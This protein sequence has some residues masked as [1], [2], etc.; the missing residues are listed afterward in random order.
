[1]MLFLNFLRSEGR[2]R[3]IEYDRRKEVGCH[4]KNYAGRNYV[5]IIAKVSLHQVESNLRVDYDYHSHFYP[6]PF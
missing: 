4:L 5:K 6:S 3:G 2:R 1:M